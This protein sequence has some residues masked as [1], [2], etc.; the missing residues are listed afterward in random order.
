MSPI[1]F[2]DTSFMPAEKARLP[3]LSRAVLYGEG[4]FE[5]L[6]TYGGRPFA[7]REHCER[8]R[9]SARALRVPLPPGL[10]GIPQIIASLLAR[11]GL[12]DAV[13]RISVLAGPSAGRSAA[14]GLAA[15]AA[16]SY[17][18][19][20]ARKIPRGLAGQQER[21]ISVVTRAA[22]A[23]FLA[24]HKATS[25]LRSVEARRGR[26]GEREVLF[27]DDAGRI[28]EGAASN[29]FAIVGGTLITPPA[30]GR[31]LPGIA[32]RT[33]MEAAAEA[34]HRVRERHLDP[35]LLGT[36]DGL[37]ITSSV[38]ELLPVIGRDGREIGHGKPHPL[39]RALHGLYRERVREE[40]G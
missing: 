7:L 24:A 40:T 19:V 30:A 22:G 21:G 26:P 37:F 20:S 31:I 10:G 15:T 1:V 34:G 12:R 6:R 8:L 16:R 2:F 35:K 14:G 32:R 3:A 18:L 36:V 17:L 4:L 28:L 38:I 11:N 9:G 27:L 29:V 25:Y 23:P 5:T 33:V 39:C 13:V